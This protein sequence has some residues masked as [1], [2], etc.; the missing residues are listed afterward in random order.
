MEEYI[1]DFNTRM[2]I[3]I[4]DHKPNGDVYAIDFDT[5]QILGFYRAST[6]DTCDFN[7]RMVRTKGNT[8]VQFI[9]ENQAK[10]KA[11]R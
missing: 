5:R 8:V 7:T 2:I 1:R 11:Q 3:G 4:L 10:K 6:N 9:F